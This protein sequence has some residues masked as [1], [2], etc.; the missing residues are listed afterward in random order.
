V[1]LH[2]ELGQLQEVPVTG[3]VLRVHVRGNGESLLLL[4]GFFANS[5]LWRDVVPLLAGEYRCITPDLPMGFHAHA[6]DRG[7]DLSLPGLARLLSE[8][9]TA[10]GVR[11][12][13]VVGNDVGG[14]LAQVFA[15]EHP[16]RVERLVLTPC[17]SFWNCPAHLLK[18]L[19]WACFLPGSVRLG[20]FLFRSPLL[21]RLAH[22]CS[23]KR[24]VPDDV[25]LATFA[26]AMTS[27]AVRRDL[28]AFVR[29]LRPRDTL[30]AA[31]VLPELG[32]PAAVVWTRTLWFPMAHARRLAQLLGG[33]LHVVDDSGAFVPED[34][35]EE[36]AELI[37]RLIAT[38]SPVAAETGARVD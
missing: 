9:M 1:S 37:H 25:L 10:L 31:R 20:A 30:R 23:A 19:R 22:R 21:R 32:C 18:P 35:P 11:R 7:A 29:A 6:M 17:D 34:R 16:D 28:A 5:N 24:R 4:H 27:A 8:T 15:A 38:T 36:V 33:W 3:G 12:A 26:P 13:T 14:A 2:P